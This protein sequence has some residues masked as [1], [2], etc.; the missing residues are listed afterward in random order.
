MGDLFKGVNLAK[1]TANLVK[2]A[3]IDLDL[4]TH[5]GS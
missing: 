1:G 5:L 2:E 3:V 4:T